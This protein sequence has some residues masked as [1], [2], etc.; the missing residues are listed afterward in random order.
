MTGANHCRGC[1]S[2]TTTHVMHSPLPLH[3]P[4]SPYDTASHVP[5]LPIYNPWCILVGIDEIWSTLLNN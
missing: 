4:D 5:S 1:Q 2:T 3:P